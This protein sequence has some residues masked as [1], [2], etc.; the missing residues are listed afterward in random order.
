[1]PS[2]RAHRP[3]RPPR[4]VKVGPRVCWHAGVDHVSRPL[5]IDAVS[6]TLRGRQDPNPP[7]REALHRPVPLALAFG[8]GAVGG[9]DRR[10][11]H[12]GRPV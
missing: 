2:S 5:K 3:P 11:S 6:H 8:H 10:R 4:A 1:M 7:V 9:V 12:T